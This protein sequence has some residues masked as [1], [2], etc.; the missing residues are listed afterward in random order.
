[1]AVFT[2]SNFIL[3]SVVGQGKQLANRQ[4]NNLIHNS[5]L[6]SHFYLAALGKSKPPIITLSCEVGGAPLA[7]RKLRGILRIAY[8]IKSGL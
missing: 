7:A 3:S 8:Q 6:K 2:M 1:M 5:H 4:F